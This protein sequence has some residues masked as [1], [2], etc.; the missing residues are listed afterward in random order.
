MKKSK[1]DA[2]LWE[3][4][5]FE[6]FIYPEATNISQENLDSVCF[7]NINELSVSRDED[8]NIKLTCIS[9]MD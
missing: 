3:Q 8:Y 4:N 5:L 7:E 9:H 6:S 2:L 1:L